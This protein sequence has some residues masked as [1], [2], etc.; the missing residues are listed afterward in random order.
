MAVGIEHPDDALADALTI[1]RDQ[2]QRAAV[3]ALRLVVGGN[4]VAGVIGELFMS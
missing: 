2:E 1:V 3:V 4:V